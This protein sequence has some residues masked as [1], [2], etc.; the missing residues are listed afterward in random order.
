MR[1]AGS[2]TLHSTDGKAGCRQDGGVMEGWGEE[3]GSDVRIISAGVSGM[4][5]GMVGKQGSA[6]TKQ[7]FTLLLD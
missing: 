6:R 2:N 1:R 5:F 3:Q 7:Q 4:L